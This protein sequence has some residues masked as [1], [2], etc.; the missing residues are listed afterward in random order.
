[1]V[2]EFQYQKKILTP[3][4][5]QIQ[6]R[7]SRT[8]L[9]LL[10]LVLLAFFY[11]LGGGFCGNR[12]PKELQ[13]YVTK[14]NELADQSNRVAQGFNNLRMPDVPR[15][16]LSSRLVRY[17]SEGK[18]IEDKAKSVEVPRALEK[19]HAYLRLSFELRASA[20]K[21]YRPAVFN[22]L[23]DQDLEVA[24]GQ[25]ARALKDLAL[26]DRAYALYALEAKE[27]LREKKVYGVSP[28]TSKFLPEDDYEKTKLVPY[29]RQLK[30][31]KS[32]EE[33][34]GLALVDLVVEPKYVG[35]NPAKKLF[36][37]PTTQKI[38]VKVTVHNQGNQAEVNLPVKAT[39]KSE[40][41]PQEKSAQM[42]IDTIAPEQKQTVEL[43]DLRP[44]PGRVVNLLTVTV[45][46]VP[47]EK[48]VKNNV[49]E[50]KFV[51]P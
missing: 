11:I 44:T 30:G 39:L 2:M 34:H 25:V 21:R 8:R 26:S 41:Q 7:R 46:P 51:L 12:E 43:T 47:N 40:A 38:S 1:V 31:V 20:L 49:R 28:V 16:E 14:V 18:G 50:Y 10:I 35:Y 4:T 36:S 22:A 6:R 37:L 29:L 9:V 24:S 32:L 42:L 17:S 5:R 15:Q 27:V 13:A 3:K 48:F 23:K 19:A 45:G 33:V